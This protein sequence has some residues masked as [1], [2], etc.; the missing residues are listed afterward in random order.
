[1]IFA[2]L[3]YNGSAIYLSDAPRE[4]RGFPYTLTSSI[5]FP[6]GKIYHDYIINIDE[7]RQ[8]TRVPW[9]GYARTEYG[10]ITIAHQA[11]AFWGTVVPPR[12]IS[13]DIFY[14]P[15]PPWGATIQNFRVVSGSGYLSSFSRESITY[16]LHERDEGWAMATTES[17]T[18]K[19][20]LDA[21]FSVASTTMGLDYDNALIRTVNQPTV[22]YTINDE[23]KLL[24]V[25]DEIAAACTHRFVIEWTGSA[26]T[27]RLMDVFASRA[28]LDLTMQ[29]ATPMVEYIAN[30]PARLFSAQWPRTSTR[31][32]SL[33]VRERADGAT[34]GVMA[35]AQARTYASVG[36]ITALVPTVTTNSESISYP[37]SNLVDANLSTDWRTISGMEPDWPSAD[38][39]YLNMWRPAGQV[40][41]EYELV[42]SYAGGQYA[43][44]LWDLYAMDDVNS[45]YRRL[46]TVESRG[47][48][49]GESRKFQLPQE[50][51][52]DVTVDGSDAYGETIATD[53]ICSLS[54]GI[55]SGSLGNIKTVYER[56]RVRM[57]LPLQAA[58]RIPRIGDRCTYVDTAVFGGVSSWFKVAAVT[59]DLNTQTIVV[60]G[61]GELV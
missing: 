36:S 57:Q 47:W 19:G 61:E 37:V 33:R 59:W 29:D 21:V 25:L 11:M 44:G 12:R 14:V 54:H 41:A 58:E 10:A 26:F 46:L 51:T 28:N 45:T 6:Q 30:P 13:V 60:E 42:S 50:W 24:D 3:T 16:S 53:P 15:D 39:V 55:I 20:T 38:G 52:W 48:G 2:D 34:N 9:G 7:V 31:G 23:R 27:L 43:P 40:V 35:V 56:L 8:A 17:T 32:V 4:H 18:Y 1:M 49:A 5:V 22:D